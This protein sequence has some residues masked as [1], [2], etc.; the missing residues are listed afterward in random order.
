MRDVARGHYINTPLVIHNEG[1][2]IGNDI[3]MLLFFLQSTNRI[4]ITDPLPTPAEL[5]QSFVKAH[6][7]Q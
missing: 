7:Q 4:H 2:E 3:H 1:Q 5:A 6:M